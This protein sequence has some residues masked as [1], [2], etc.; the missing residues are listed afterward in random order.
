MTSKEEAIDE[1]IRLRKGWRESQINAESDGNS[2]WS[3]LD[4][5]IYAINLAIDIVNEIE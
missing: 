5:A 2:D 3:I 4:G 1:L